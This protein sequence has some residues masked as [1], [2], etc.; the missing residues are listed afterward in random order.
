[1]PDIFEL[2]Q[3]AST[4]ITTIVRLGITLWVPRRGASALIRLGGPLEVK[5]SR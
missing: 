2:A 4:A 1:L 5:A 3:P